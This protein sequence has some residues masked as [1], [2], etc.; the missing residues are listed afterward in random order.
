MRLFWWFLCGIVKGLLLMV[1][2]MELV[3]PSTIVNGG[4]L[5]IV[6]LWFVV[7]KP[8]SRCL[9]CVLVILV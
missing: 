9:L 3:L 6:M 5:C 4:E 2:C 7:F 8:N 1:R